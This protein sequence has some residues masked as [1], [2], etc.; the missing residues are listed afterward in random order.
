M[1]LTAGPDE[2]DSVHGEKL[3]SW[4]DL[5]TQ[6]NGARVQAHWIAAFGG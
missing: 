5:G 4:E 1:T 6:E 2:R 3:P